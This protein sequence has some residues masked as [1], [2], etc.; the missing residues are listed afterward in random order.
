MECLVFFQVDNSSLTG[1]SDPLPRATEC[2]SDNP[3]ETKNMAFFSSNAVEGDFS[4]CISTHIEVAVKYFVWYCQ[5]LIATW[6]CFTI[7]LEP[8]YCEDLSCI[9][10]IHTYMNY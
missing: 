1:E 3:L 9:H 5:I 8:R 6:K 2:T 4:S 7:D 10:Y